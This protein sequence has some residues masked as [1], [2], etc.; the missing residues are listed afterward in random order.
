VL[1]VL[2][3]YT[4]ILTNNIELK[5]LSLVLAI[6]GWYAIHVTISFEREMRGVPLQLR[7]QGGV[8]VLE[9]SVQAV[10]VTVIGSRQEVLAL[11]R[12]QLNVVVDLIEQELPRS[13]VVAI[14]P[15][16]VVTVR[17]VRALRLR[18]SSV[19]IQLAREEQKKIPIK[20]RWSGKPEGADV[21]SVDVDPE[22]VVIRG[23]GSELAQTEEAMTE[24]IDVAGRTKTLKERVGFVSPSD[25]WEAIY[26]PPTAEV[27]IG[28]LRRTVTIT[29]EAVPLAAFT[30]PG[31]PYSVMVEP[32]HVN[33]YLSG[34]PDLQGSMRASAVRA[35]VFCDGL[36]PGSTNER[37]VMVHVPSG[38]S[39]VVRAD[40]ETVRVVAVAGAPTA[41]P[42]TTEKE[43]RGP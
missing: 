36:V 3:P 24:L 5:V 9:Q 10:D 20:V 11:D 37:P 13:G 4:R 28:I 22:W 25:R 35:F 21:T 23:P 34:P 1:D 14:G 12:E 7:T 41:V 33:V 26:D 30:T 15:Q 43:E 39:A 27:T 42:E 40:P 16:N 17:G 38:S 29:R 8:A 19:R 32:M 18:P 6:I 2:K 31:T